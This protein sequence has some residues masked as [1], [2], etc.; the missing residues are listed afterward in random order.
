MIHVPSSNMPK[1]AAAQNGLR[2]SVNGGQIAA[3]PLQL[4]PLQQD[5]G[6]FVARLGHGGFGNETT[7]PKF[8]GRCNGS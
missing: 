8:Y 1:A 2:A 3:T 7:N 6:G 4:L 5:S